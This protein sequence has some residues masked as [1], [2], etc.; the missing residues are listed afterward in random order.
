MKQ[1]EVSDCTDSTNVIIYC[2]QQIL[3]RLH[4]GKVRQ[5]RSSHVQPLPDL[6]PSSGSVRHVSV[7]K[8]HGNATYF[9]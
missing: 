5:H 9:S 1:E 7:S 3:L 6:F 4:P 2:T 8:G